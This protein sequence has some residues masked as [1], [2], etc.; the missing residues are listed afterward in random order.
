MELCCT[1]WLYQGRHVLAST[2]IIICVYTWQLSY[3]HQST[4]TPLTSLWRQLLGI[5]KQWLVDRIYYIAIFWV[6]IR[7]LL[8]KGVNLHIRINLCF[9]L[10]LS[11]S[12]RLF[13]IRIKVDFFHI[14]KAYTKYI[15]LLCLQMIG[16]LCIE[17]TQELWHYKISR[18][19]F[20]PLNDRFYIH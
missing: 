15:F 17:M 14:Y 7:F 11:Q 5:I 19:L 8:T 4:L 10:F 12:F 13:T 20:S 3:C 18:V 9:S 6:S 2:H 16:A 1:S